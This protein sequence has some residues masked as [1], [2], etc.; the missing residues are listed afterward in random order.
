MAEPAPTRTEA[1]ILRSRGTGSLVGTLIGAGW[2]ASG[3][4]ALPNAVRVP[5]GLA[6]VGVV[7]FLLG[8]S[9][10][11]I[12]SSRKL[13]APDD[14][15]RTANRRV[16]RWFW[17]NLLGEIVLLNVAV[18]LLIAP[19]LSIY[20]IPAISLVVGLH[21]LP[22]AW[23]FAVRSYR[24]CGGAMIAVAALTAGGVWAEGVHR[25]AVL[26]AMEAVVNAGILWATVAWGT[27]AFLRHGGGLD[28]SPGGSQ[29][30]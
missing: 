27:H 20:W 22:M 9:R 29:G 21:F 6:G 23:F 8:R 18:N 13:P 25:G 15:A 1:Q 28:G 24:A 3:L 17:L 10:R 14:A 5:L 2:M 4:T 30:R 7:V 12:A 26:V 19:H 11:M 16:W